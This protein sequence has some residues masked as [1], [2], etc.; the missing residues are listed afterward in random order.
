MARPRGYADWNP[1]HDTLV[2]LGQVSEVLRE[3][4]AHLPLTARQIFYRLVGSHGYDKTE[5][6]YARLCEYLVR[7]RRAQMISFDAIRDDGTTHHPYLKYTSPT[8]FWEQVQGNAD[9]YVR[10]KLEDQPV[11][12]ELWCEAAGMVPQME[13]IA[14]P[15]SVPVY[16][17]GASRR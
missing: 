15:Y 5:R 9:H 12:V 4:Q 13:R 17:T 10:D 7:A 8:D 3:Y 14:Q 11:Y 6:A 16:S 1:K 2:V